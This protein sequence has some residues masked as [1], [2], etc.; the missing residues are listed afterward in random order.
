ML[1]KSSFSVCLTLNIGFFDGSRHRRFLTPI[2]GWKG[3]WVI[4]GMMVHALPLL[5]FEAV[6]HDGDVEHHDKR[7]DKRDHTRVTKL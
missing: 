3:V 1:T 2:G 5:R 6:R 7:T 4:E